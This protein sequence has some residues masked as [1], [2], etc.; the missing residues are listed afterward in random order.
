[1]RHLLCILAI[2]VFA[3][4]GLANTSQADNSDGCAK[5]GGWCE[6]GNTKRAGVCAHGSAKPALY[7]HCDKPI[8]HHDGGQQESQPCTCKNTG[9]AGACGLGPIKEGMY[10]HCD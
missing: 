7:C 9:K 2:S 3:V 10:C 8:T 1:M 6:C 5:D 4:L